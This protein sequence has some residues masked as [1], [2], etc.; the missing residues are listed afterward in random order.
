MEWKPFINGVD[1]VALNDAPCWLLE[2]SS[3]IYIEKTRKGYT[4]CIE[5]WDDA[6]SLSWY[7]EMFEDLEFDTP[8]DAQKYAEVLLKMDG[9]LF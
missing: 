7:E 3:Q 9:F 5:R 8:D 2:S 1:G 4:L 6:G